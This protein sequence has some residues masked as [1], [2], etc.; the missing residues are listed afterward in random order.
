MLCDPLEPSTPNRHN[1]LTF[2][3]ADH[4]LKTI[5]R[6]LLAGVGA[7]VVT[8]LLLIA[9][10]LA[11]AVVHPMPPDSRGTHEE[12]CAHVARYPAW[13]LAAVVPI[14]AATAF[15]GAWIAGR[16]G[17]LIGGLFVGALIFAA[18]AFNLSMLPYPLWFKGGCLLAI[19]LAIAAALYASRRAPTAPLIAPA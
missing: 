11:S 15:V 14:W 18:L 1:A 4:M 12:V 10:E 13:V 16:F 5:L 17:S 3:R 8:M 7:L 9:V 19:P 2:S 6:T